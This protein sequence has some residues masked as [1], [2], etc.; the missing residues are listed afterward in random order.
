M[1]GCSDDFHLSHMLEIKV[2]VISIYATLIC[3]VFWAGSNSQGFCMNE[4]LTQSAS[5]RENKE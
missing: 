2:C 5:E 4:T 1:L 3:S